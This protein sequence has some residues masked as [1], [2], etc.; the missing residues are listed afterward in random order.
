MN[1]FQKD[2]INCERDATVQTMWSLKDY[3]IRRSGEWKVSSWFT[4]ED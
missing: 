4:S 3:I 1:S 2:I